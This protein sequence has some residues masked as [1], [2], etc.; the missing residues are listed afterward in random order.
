[1]LSLRN[2]NFSNPDFNRQKF[3]EYFDFSHEDIQRLRKEMKTLISNLISIKPPIQEI[4]GVI[5]SDDDDDIITIVNEKEAIG[6]K[7]DQKV[8]KRLVSNHTH[9]GNDNKSGLDGL[10]NNETN[11]SEGNTKEIKPNRKRGYFRSFKVAK[12]KRMKIDDKNTD[13]SVGNITH[14]RHDSKSEWGGNISHKSNERDKNPKKVKERRG[15]NKSHES[16]KS[17]ET[18][19]IVKENSEKGRDSGMTTN[20]STNTLKLT[21]YAKMIKTSMERGV[22]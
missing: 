11:E 2:R 21:E 12:N 19:K 16:D 3:H 4:Q 15:N 5:S 6:N 8:P 22:K 17:D 10:K 20:N 14:D 9:E 18:A 1:M 7:M 13:I